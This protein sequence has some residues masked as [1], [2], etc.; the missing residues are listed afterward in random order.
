[1][2][3]PVIWQVVAFRLR[4]PGRVG[5]AVQFTTVPPPSVALTGVIAIPRL[6]VYADG[7]YESV[8]AAST[9]EIVTLGLVP[10][11]ALLEFAM[12]YAVAVER[13]VGVPVSVQFE[14]SVIPA[15]SVDVVQVVAGLPPLAGVTVEIG[16]PFVKI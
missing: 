9:T 13:A 6:K 16:T 15:G 8:G 7:E 5:D 11:P 12:V 10:D 3:V 14:F 2:G 1:L 4:V